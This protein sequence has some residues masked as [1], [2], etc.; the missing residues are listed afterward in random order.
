MTTTTTAPPP[1]IVPSPE[2][3]T[4][5]VTAWRVTSRR[6]PHLS[7]VVRYDRLENAF[8]CQCP[9]AFY[10]GHCFHIDQ[11][12]AALTAEWRRAKRGAA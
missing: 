2:D 10:R 7:Y 8:T 5:Y 12:I 1:T 3:G 11:A 9:A 4:P 6:H